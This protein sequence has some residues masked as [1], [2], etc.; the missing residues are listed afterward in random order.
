[1][2]VFCLTRPCGA[3]HRC[4]TAL[5][6]ALSES[7]RWQSAEAALML[8][9]KVADAWTSVNFDSDY[10]DEENGSAPIGTLFPC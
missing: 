7:T 5:C 10:E 3:S 9:G 6:G 2:C 4:L 8:L 1:M